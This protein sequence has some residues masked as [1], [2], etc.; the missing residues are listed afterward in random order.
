MIASLREVAPSEIE[1]GLDREIVIERP[2]AQD[3]VAAWQLRKA[4]G[5]E[6]TSCPVV[7]T[8][9]SR[10]ARPR[11]HSRSRRPLAAGS[12]MSV[13]LLVANLVRVAREDLDGARLLA[14]SENR[15]AIYPG[16]AR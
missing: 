15:T 12:S 11:T 6:L 13:E 7:R 9:S 5:V 16:S 10:I 14:A 2:R 3:G 4:A 8:T 1:A